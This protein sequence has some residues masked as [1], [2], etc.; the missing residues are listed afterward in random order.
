M[1]RRTATGKAARNQDPKLVG[2]N[3]GNTSN[4]NWKM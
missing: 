2:Q 1:L 4:F 3:G